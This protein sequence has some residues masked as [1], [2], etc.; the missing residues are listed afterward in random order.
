MINKIPDQSFLEFY[1]Q[2][3]RECLCVY[4]VTLTVDENH[5]NMIINVPSENRD[6]LEKT[7]NSDSINDFKVLNSG[8]ECARISVSLVSI[9]KKIEEMFKNYLFYQTVGLLDPTTAKDKIMLIYLLEQ[10][11]DLIEH[12][13]YEFRKDRDVMLAAVEV[14]SNAI[15]LADPSLLNDPSF[16]K[17]AAQRNSDILYSEED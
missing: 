14:D 9:S 13:H 2:H 8:K 1:T 12:A 7:L 6:D 3:L 17:E 15:L 11:G 5:G 10:Y 4:D 16:I